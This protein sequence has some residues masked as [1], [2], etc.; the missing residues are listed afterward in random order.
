MARR[1]WLMI[2]VINSTLGSLGCATTPYKYSRFHVE[3]SSPEERQTVQFEY[4]K[5]HR[6]LDRA[7]WIVALP[8]RI[9]PFHPKVNS[10]N[11]SQETAEKL[12]HY[13]EANDLTDVL[14]RVN[15]Y[16]PVGEW[17]RMRENSRIAFGWKYTFGTAN[18]L[19]YTLIPS[20]VFGGDYYNPYSNSLSVSSDV[21]AILIT[22]AAYAKDIHSQALPGTYAS[23]NQFPVLTLWRYTRAV[24]D[25]L[26]YARHQDDWELERETCATVFPMLGIQAAL[27]GHTATGLVMVLPSI[28]VPIAMIGGAVAGHTVGQTV[29]AKREHEIESRKSTRIPLNSSEAETDDSESKTQ[30]V[31]FTESPP[32][33][34]PKGRP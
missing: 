6:G 17:Q 18:W 3:A 1:S 15:Q 11:L 7:A 21:P 14:V 25:S 13:L 22:E 9:L 8:S 10:H 24:N 2:L 30:L 19:G 12:E 4:G 5:P 32:D 16:D 28:T 27:G 29:I 34:K 20:R 31:G 33:E 23:I 26:G